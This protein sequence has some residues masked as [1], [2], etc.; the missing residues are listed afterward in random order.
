VRARIGGMLL[1]AVTLYHV[2]AMMPHIAA[3]S[4]YTLA[5]V[6]TLMVGNWAFIATAMRVGS[7]AESVL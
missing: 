5:I 6:A 7:L 2:D 1:M 3:Q 4:W